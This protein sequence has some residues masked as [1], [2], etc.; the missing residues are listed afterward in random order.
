[1]QRRSIVLVVER[2]MIVTAALVGRR[3]GG[4]RRGRGR[5]V[6]GRVLSPLLRRL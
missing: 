1:M 3:R 4:V 5:R 2:V 6:R